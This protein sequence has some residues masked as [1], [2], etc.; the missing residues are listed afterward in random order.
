MSDEKK[1]GNKKP[2]LEDHKEET[3]KK[4]KKAKTNDME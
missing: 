4:D 2:L 1:K 3:G